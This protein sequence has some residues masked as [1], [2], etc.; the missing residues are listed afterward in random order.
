MVALRENEAEV[1]YGMGLEGA[2]RMVIRR[3]AGPGTITTLKSFASD[4]P[5]LK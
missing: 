2:D 1:W 4:K 5:R 3:M